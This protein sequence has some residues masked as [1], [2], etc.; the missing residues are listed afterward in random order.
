M[1]SSDIKVSSNSEHQK[2]WDLLPWYINHSLDSAEQ[3]IVIK[4]IKTC[5]TCK[6]ELNKQ[7]QVFDNIQ[8]TDI[9]QQVSQVSFVHLL[10][11]IDEQPKLHILPQNNVVEKES[12][13]FP[14]QLSG[15][16]RYTALAASVL[17]LILPFIL[18]SLVDKP[19][20]KSDYRTLANSAEGKEK[21]NLIR[22]VFTDQS[23][24]EQIE[25]ILKNVSGQIVKAP[26]E[27]GVYLVQIGNQQTSPEEIKDA[28]SHLHKNALVIFA[29][30]TH[31]LPSSD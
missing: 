1:L 5:I 30:Q 6:I 22:I 7:Q 4:H 28:I 20:L 17:L 13:F 18:D 25:A 19:E 21:H 2:V 23:N 14:H 16:V 3:D 8:E 12:K 27:T 31:G 10:E 29:E 11:R 15:F 26:A 24:P 9:L